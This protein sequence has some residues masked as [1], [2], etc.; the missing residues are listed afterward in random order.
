MAEIYIGFAAAESR[1]K[2]QAKA[3]EL[4]PESPASFRAKT[5]R[6][7]FGQE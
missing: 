7:G 6:L 1:A 5:G 2:K 3:E 4:Q